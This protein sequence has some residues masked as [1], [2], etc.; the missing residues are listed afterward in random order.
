MDAL[1][2]DAATLVKLGSIA[3]HAEEMLSPNGHPLDR[4]ALE[5]LLDDPDVQAWMDAADD[6]ALLPVLR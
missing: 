5:A 2:P 1:H 6:F 4:A 3:R